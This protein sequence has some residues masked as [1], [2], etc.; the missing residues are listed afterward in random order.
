ME[1]IEETFSKMEKT[2]NRELTDNNGILIKQQLISSKEKYDS[3][4][5]QFIDLNNNGRLD[6]K[7]IFKNK[8]A[9]IT[10]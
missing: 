8:F 6:S 9:R 4:P 7:G 5:L 2:V 3:K 1:A 10:H